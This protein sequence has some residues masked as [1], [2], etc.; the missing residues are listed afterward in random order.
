[1]FASKFFTCGKECGDALEM[2]SITRRIYGFEVGAIS[3]RS[4]ESR[5]ADPRFKRGPKNPPWHEYELPLRA[6]HIEPSGAEI[7]WFLFL[8]PNSGSLSATRYILSMVRFAYDAEFQE[9]NWSL[10][11]IPF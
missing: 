3:N 7:L 1:M 9:F 6:W 10:E 8:N 11:C 2:A 4:H 5:G